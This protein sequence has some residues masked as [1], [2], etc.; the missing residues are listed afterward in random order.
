MEEGLEIQKGLLKIEPSGGRFW[1]SKKA[2]LRQT[3]H[4]EGLGDPKRLT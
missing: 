1:R 3:P 2:Y 4:V